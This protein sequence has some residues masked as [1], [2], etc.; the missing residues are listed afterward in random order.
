MLRDRIKGYMETLKNIQELGENKTPYALDEMRN[1]LHRQILC[2]LSKL[3][4]FKDFSDAYIRSKTIFENLDVICEIFSSCEEWKL[5]SDGDVSA[6]TTYLWHY[7]AASETLM[8]L[9]GRLNLPA[10]IRR[11]IEKQVGEA[12]RAEFYATGISRWTD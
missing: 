9:E 6:M 12:V 5:E 10:H 8:Y 1:K 2:T 11:L 3:A 4:D 7:L